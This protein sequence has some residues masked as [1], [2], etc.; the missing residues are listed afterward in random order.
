MQVLLVFLFATA[1]HCSILRA[2]HAPP[3]RSD[4]AFH[5]SRPGENRLLFNDL[6]LYGVYG[7]SFRNHY[8][9]P[10]IFCSHAK[11]KCRM[12][13]SIPITFIL[14]PYRDF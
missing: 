2:D 4:V 7:D 9:K 3:L 13:R 10:Q 1:E 14:Q 5:P 11:V 8:R 12:Q 6:L